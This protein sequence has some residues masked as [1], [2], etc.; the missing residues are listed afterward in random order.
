MKIKYKVLLLL[1]MSMFLLVAI[2]IILNSKENATYEY[3]LEEKAI[4]LQPSP[5]GQF[6]IT[7]TKESG[8]Y[9]LSVWHV[10]QNKKVGEFNSR[11]K[12]LGSVEWSSDSKHFLFSSQD[13]SLFLFDINQANV[14]SVWDTGNSK[15]FS[16]D[17]EN[18]TVV[19]GKQLV[20]ID[21]KTLEPVSQIQFQGQRPHKVVGWSE[22]GIPRYVIGSQEEQGHALMDI[23]EDSGVSLIENNLAG[24][25]H[26]ISSS[27]AVN[28]HESIY[29]RDS[30]LRL[31][32]FNLQSEDIT[33][34]TNHPVSLVSLSPDGTK[35]GSYNN[36]VNVFNLDDDLEEEYSQLKSESYLKLWEWLNNNEFITVERRV[37]FAGFLGESYHTEIHDISTG[38]KKMSMRIPK[39]LMDNVYWAEKAQQ[40]F[41]QTEDR[42]LYVYDI[43]H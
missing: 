35:V 42:E 10:A 18:V 16:P 43:E 25:T 27:V 37:K 31:Y 32:E 29:F 17:E 33:R 8:F 40:I 1:L 6:Y 38:E 13:S 39:P 12:S 9:Q 3:S 19:D 7:T 34:K 14:E 41:I 22:D 21:L 24:N 36:G 15:Q 2:W 20:V 23:T 11:S 28:N 26:Y 30:E 5:D 4:L